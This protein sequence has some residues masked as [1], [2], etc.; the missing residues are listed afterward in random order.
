MWEK[1]TDYYFFIF[2]LMKMSLLLS[3]NNLKEEIRKI[4]KKQKR[5]VDVTWVAG[6]VG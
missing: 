1:G 6:S 4:N 3:F 2:S 5:E